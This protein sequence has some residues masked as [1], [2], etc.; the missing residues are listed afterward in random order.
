METTTS[1]ASDLETVARLAR[2]LCDDET[3]VSDMI[4]QIATERNSQ[5]GGSHRG[6]LTLLHDDTSIVSTYPCGGVMG[7]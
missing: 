2:K 1:T 7:R 3:L 6:L 5:D 4:G